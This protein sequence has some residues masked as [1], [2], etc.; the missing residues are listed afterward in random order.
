VVKHQW[1]SLAA[2]YTAT[3]TAA[4]ENGEAEKGHGNKGVHPQRLLS[5]L[6]RR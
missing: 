2:F 6:A 3:A 5:G 4:P 1:P